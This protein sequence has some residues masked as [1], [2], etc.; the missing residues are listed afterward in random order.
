MEYLSAMNLLS[1]EIKKQQLELSAYAE[2]ENSSEWVIENKNESISRLIECYNQLYLPFPNL[3]LALGN[4]M[5]RLLKIDKNLSG[6]H[7][8]INNKRDS[9]YPGF[10]QCNWIP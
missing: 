3:L 6:F 1:E 8:L 7:I 10:I 2:K 4:E 9:G 5:E